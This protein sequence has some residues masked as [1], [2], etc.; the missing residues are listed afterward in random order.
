MRHGP[1][2]RGVKSGHQVGRG[3]PASWSAS[4]G[5]PRVVVGVADHS[6]A[7]SIVDQL[8][9]T[10]W[11]VPV[12]TGAGADRRLGHGR[13]HR[14]R[15][16][17]GGP[18]PSGDRPRRR[19]GCHVCRVGRGRSMSRVWWLRWVQSRNA[20]TFRLRAAFSTSQRSMCRWVQSASVVPLSRSQAMSAMAARTSARAWSV[21]PAVRSASRERSR[22]SRSWCHV[23]KSR[24][25]RG[26]GS[27]TRVARAFPCGHPSGRRN[28]SRNGWNAALI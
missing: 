10:L 16:E 26:G 1:G 5:K 24:T 25:I 17:G 2:C 3:D 8:V 20:R 22:S 11:T 28:C 12:R 23:A 6:M 13:R 21:C 15:A 9:W 19:L 27:G 7:A 18:A 14:R 4:R